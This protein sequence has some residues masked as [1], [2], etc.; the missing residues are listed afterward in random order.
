MISRGYVQTLS[1]LADENPD[2]DKS[3]L[4]ARVDSLSIREKTSS[5]LGWTDPDPAGSE[6]PS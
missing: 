4:S 5:T 1:K 6:L 3:E 2:L